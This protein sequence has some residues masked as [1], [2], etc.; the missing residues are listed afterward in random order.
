MYFFL[1]IIQKKEKIYYFLKVNKGNIG[2][3]LVKYLEKGSFCNIYNGLFNKLAKN[4]E[5]LSFQIGEN[6][7]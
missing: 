6:K 2:F 5:D 1:C 7:G 3:A 4:A